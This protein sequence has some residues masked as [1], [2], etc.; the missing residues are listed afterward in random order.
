MT[1]QLK[2]TIDRFFSVNPILRESSK[3]LFLIAAG[4]DK[5][6]WAMDTLK[7]NYYALCNYLHWHQGGIVLAFGS[8]TRKDVEN[9]EYQTAAR[10]LGEGL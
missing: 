5:D 8:N 9:S 2:R 6:N 7:A 4:N 3:K 1:A 10:N